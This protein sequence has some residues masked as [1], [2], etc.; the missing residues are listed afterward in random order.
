VKNH[1]WG[2]LIGCFFDFASELFA[3]LLDIPSISGRLGGLLAPDVPVGVLDGIDV[4][5]LLWRMKRLKLDPNVEP[6]LKNIADNPPTTIY[7][8]AN[9]ARTWV[10]A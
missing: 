5:I 1:Q 10:K 8:G 6:V 9:E 7:A 3:R 2:K 4:N